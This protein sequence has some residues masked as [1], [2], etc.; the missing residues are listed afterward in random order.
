MRRVVIT[1]M[2]VV[3]PVGIGQKEN[4]ASIISSKS[5][6]API[7]RFDASE[8]KSRIAGEIKNLDATKY[9]TLKEV[10]RNDRFC[11]IIM[12]A[13]QEAVEDSGLE[14]CDED[15][16]RIA[17]I[18]G[19]GIGGMYI[20][21]QQV[22]NLITRGPNRV[23]P[24]LVPAMITDTAAGLLSIKYGFR[25]PNYDVTS[26]CA[27]GAHAIGDSYMN[28][29]SGYADIVVTGGVEGPLS[30]VGVAGFTALKALSVRNDEPEKASRPFENNRDGF[31]IAEGG[32]VLILEEYER[33]KK[34]NARIYAELKGYGATGDAYHITA[35]CLDG[36]GAAR[37]MKVSLK[38]AELNPEDIDYC[39]AHGTS[40]KYNDVT[41]TIALKTVFG[42]HAA[43]LPVSS[44]KSMTGHM[45]GGTGAVEAVYSILSIKNNAVP[46]TINYEEPDPECD[47]D[48]V[49][50]TARELPV[51]HVM[52][53]NF[54]FGGHNASLIFSEL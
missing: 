38:D 42:E 18:I 30:P 20:Y 31:V 3:S 46:P 47:L 10:K 45:L 35:P 5:G 25:G 9:M 36:D 52:T 26:A 4:W 54:G 17:T 33:A 14:L 24:F 41:E 21:E 13:G 29:R 7:T 19:V 32:A 8:Y 48:Y 27:S 43:S 53:N 16:E 15:S 50:N 12:A 22:K 40:T 44:T 6:I 1:G 39:N 34:R 11:H 37:A 23:S 51:K 49:P 2:G 28:I